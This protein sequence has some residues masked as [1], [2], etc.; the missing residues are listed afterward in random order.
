MKTQMKFQ[1]I[2][3]FVALIASVLCLL[4]SLGFMTGIYDLLYEFSKENGTPKIGGANLYYEFQPFNKTLTQLSIA[5]ILLAVFLFVTQT[6]NRRKYY[7][8]NYVATGLCVTA[9]IGVGIW[10][11]VNALQLKARYVSEV[12]W[13]KLRKKIEDV[14]DHII[15]TESTFWFDIS[16][17]VCAVLAVAAILL[18]INLI[19]K[20]QLMKHENQLLSGKE[21]RYE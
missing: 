10:A 17:A 9:D 16:L 7:V 11:V 2:V 1:K 19:W 18:V 21:A 4:Y 12:D 13:E 15:Y 8:S 20:V 5:L 14:Y 6:A 3:V